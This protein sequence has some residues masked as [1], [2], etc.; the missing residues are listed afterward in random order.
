MRKIV[1]LFGIVLA[2]AAIAPAASQPPA[3]GGDRQKLIGVWRLV[4]ITEDGKVNPMRGGKPTGYIFYTASGEMGAMIQ[5]QRAPIA[6]AGQEPSP[7]EAQ[8][9]LRGFTAYFG[10]YSVDEKAKVITHHRKG[11][12]QP[13]FEAD[14][15]R[16]YR[17][18]S[19]DRIVLGN[20]QEL[21]W[22]RVK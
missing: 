7:E 13:G 3:E 16:R 21:I 8:A 11:S 12:V 19:N 5:P 10:T 20:K 15:Q 2:M 9:A 18:D 6:M 4:S 1:P 22:E 14:V 17:F